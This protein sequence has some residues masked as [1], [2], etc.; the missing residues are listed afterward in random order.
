MMPTSAGLGNA[1]CLVVSQG[2]WSSSASVHCECLSCTLWW[3]LWLL[4]RLL[5]NSGLGKLAAAIV[6]A[7]TVPSNLCLLL[8]RGSVSRGCERGITSRLKQK[9]I[10]PIIMIMPWACSAHLFGAGR[11]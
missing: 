2:E 6:V 9:F 3:V 10:D 4:L 1:S 8:A 5:C 11:A 7:T